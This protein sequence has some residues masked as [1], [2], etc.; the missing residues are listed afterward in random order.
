MSDTPTSR[1]R[2][3]QI[4]DTHHSSFYAQDDVVGEPVAGYEDRVSTNGDLFSLIE[5]VSP[6]VPGSQ[7]V[8][9]PFEHYK[10]SLATSEQMLNCKY[11]TGYFN[12][13]I[14]N[15]EHAFAITRMSH[16][17]SYLSGFGLEFGG[18]P[19]VG[20][21]SF[22]YAGDVDGTGFV[23]APVNLDDLIASALRDVL[24]IIKPKL[25]IINSIIELKDFKSLPSTLKNLRGFDFGS[26]SPLQWLKKVHG[27]SISRHN[28]RIA[29]DVY[30]Q[31][32]FNVSP[33]IS[34]V[35]A[36]RSSLQTVAKRINDLVTR[37][38]RTQLSH[39]T[40]AYREYDDVDDTYEHNYGGYPIP[41]NYGHWVERRRVLSLPS[42]FHLQVR[43]N[44]NYT[45]Y[46]VEFAQLNGLL[47]LLG[48]NFN[49]RTVWNAIPWTFVIDWVAG[50]G[51]WLNQFRKGAMEPKINIQHCLWSMKRQRNISIS[52]TF[53]GSDIS[54]LQY[55]RDIPCLNYVE[56]AYRRSLAVPTVAA[57][58]TS[59]LN[60]SEFSLGAA[61]ILAR[62]PRHHK[63][64]R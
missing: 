39:W 28:L 9:K 16:Q 57:I 14:H 11:S 20:L 53:G 10:V 15:P 30:L 31:W 25:S 63:S 46:Q 4:P 2:T 44:Y 23:P 60:S 43:Y 41:P 58:T 62:R 45:N 5:R 27:R 13:D 29:S 18:P 51:Q 19:N 59:G 64:N 52:R 38:G 61:L 3:V 42:V 6:P 22:V 50:V 56:T 36:I 40:K 7:S 26:L 32:K 33:L 8:W 24:P 34:D 49:P 48:I 54:W 55:S 35:M 37:S 1:S 21:P 47:D 17:F 12:V